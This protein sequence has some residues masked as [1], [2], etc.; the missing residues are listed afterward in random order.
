[1]LSGKCLC[2]T[3]RFELH[4]KLGPLAY[5]HCSM[6]QRASGSAFGANAPVRARYLEWLTG[7]EVIAEYESSPGKYRAFCSKCGSP[8]YSRREFS[9]P[10]P[11]YELG[12][13]GMEPRIAY[14][15]I[16]DELMLDGNARLNL[17]TFV[18][19]WMDPE[20]EKLMSETFDKNMID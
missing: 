17:A 3:V 5:C 1:M 10:I 18:T 16:H 4:G 15:L 6:C 12:E 8:L 20:A 11:K 14:E 2:G 13:R 9:D 7:R 19:T